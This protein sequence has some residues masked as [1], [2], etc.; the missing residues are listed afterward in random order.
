MRTGIWATVFLGGAVLI[1]FLLGHPKDSDL[2]ISVPKIVTHK[3][4]AYDVSV[5]RNKDTIQPGDFARHRF[6]VKQNGNLVD[7]VGQTIFPHVA[8]VSDDLS[9]ITFYHVDRL[10]SPRDGVYEF[11]HQFIADS[12]YTLWFELND[13]TTEDHHGDQSNYISRAEVPITSSSQAVP[14]ASSR[15]V[16]IDRNYR[17]RLEA[18]TLQAG[19]PEEVRIFVEDTDGLPTQILQDYEQHFFYVAQPATGYYVLDHFDEQIAS[20][21]SVAV[22]LTLPEPGEYAFWARIFLSDGSGT[23]IDLVEGSFTIQA[24]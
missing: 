9:D 10:S 21:S 3:R 4:V 17:L 20:P 7:L 24:R 14:V 23:A 18:G 11:D 12:D 19:A 8:V 16:A 22:P 15:T 5:S 6:T 1:F 2:S 13:N